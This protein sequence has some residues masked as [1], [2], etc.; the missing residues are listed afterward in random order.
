MGLNDF[1]Q[2]LSTNV[3]SRGRQFVSTVEAKNYPISATQWHPEKN[4]FE[5]GE[6]GRLGYAAIP[7]SS[8]AVAL[9]QFVASNFVNRARRSTHRF[10]SRADEDKALIYNFA[11]TADPQGYY[12][13][14]YMWGK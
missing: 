14:I 10:A 13:Q 4:N 5:W 6:I 3:D 1:F 7:H 12:T 9:S 8:D 11:A 2:V